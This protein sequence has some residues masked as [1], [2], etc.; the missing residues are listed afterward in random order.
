ME[1]GVLG[2]DR[3]EAAGRRSLTASTL[4]AQQGLLPHAKLYLPFFNVAQMGW[5]ICLF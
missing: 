5:C 3:V 2:G 1:S 4:C